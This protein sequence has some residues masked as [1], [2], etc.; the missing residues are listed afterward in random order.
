MLQELED[1][2]FLVATE[3]SGIPVPGAEHCAIE[4]AD[5]APL[6]ALGGIMDEWL[7]E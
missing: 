1:F 2:R 5:L 7:K 3:R 6:E 4:A